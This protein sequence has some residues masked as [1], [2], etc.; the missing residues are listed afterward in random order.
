MKKVTK[1]GE[2]PMLSAEKLRLA[3]LSERAPKDKNGKLIKVAQKNELND[4]AA[5]YLALK[6]RKSRKG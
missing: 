4:P 5:L 2:N 1:L 3:L 6:D